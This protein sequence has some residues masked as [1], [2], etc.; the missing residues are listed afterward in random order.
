MAEISQTPPLIQQSSPLTQS[1]HPYYITGTT[2]DIKNIF[3]QNIVNQGRPQFHHEEIGT[4]YLMH[5][6]K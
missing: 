6:G 2:V 4:S 5:G 1:S 3:F